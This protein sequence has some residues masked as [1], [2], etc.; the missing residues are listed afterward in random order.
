MEER[1]Q[2]NE[3]FLPLFCDVYWCPFV[4]CPLEL[5][6]FRFHKLGFK[7]TIDVL[8]SDHAGVGLR[9]NSSFTGWYSNVHNWFIVVCWRCEVLNLSLC[10]DQQRVSPDYP[11]INLTAK[12]STNKKI[13]CLHPGKSVQRDPPRWIL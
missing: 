5:V 3:W 9:F 1:A 12:M 13:W 4:R 8:K 7:I 2:Q 6:W 11:Q 10:Y